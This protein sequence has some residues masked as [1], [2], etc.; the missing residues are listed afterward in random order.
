MG[1]WIWWDFLDVCMSSFRGII[2][3][4]LQCNHYPEGYGGLG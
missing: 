1:S 3:V 4:L 2:S